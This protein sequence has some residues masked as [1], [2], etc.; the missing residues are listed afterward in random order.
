MTQRQENITGAS[1]TGADGA[2][3][4]TYDLSYSDPVGAS[5][6]IVVDNSPWQLNVDYSYAAGTITF[7]KNVWNDMQITLF[8]TTTPAG[9]LESSYYCL[10]TDVKRQLRLNQEFSASTNPTETEVYS[11]IEDAMT[12][13]DTLTRRA[14]RTLTVSEERHDVPEKFV[15][16]YGVGLK[17]KLGHRFVKDFDADEGDKIEVWNGQSWED[18]VQTKTEGRANDYWV[19]NKD[20]YLHLFQRYWFHKK[21]A[22]RVTYRYGEGTVPK[23]I[24]KACTYLAAIE[25]LDSDD[26]S[27][28]VN[29]TGSGSKNTMHK[30][31]I[32]RWTRKAGALLSRY[33]DPFGF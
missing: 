20:G 31:R 30:D 14:W 23:D 15:Y 12:E 1:L 10:P 3:S 22:V 26:Y 27:A 25:V 2:A 17:L 5:L 24:R 28:M 29:D 9:G 33:Q 19:N 8:Y 32:D 16:E 11:F 21:E 6:H 18:W 13:I 4:R 7:I